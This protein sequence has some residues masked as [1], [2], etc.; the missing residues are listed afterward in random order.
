[1]WAGP[2]LLNLAGAAA[3]VE[4]EEEAST[5]VVELEALAELGGEVLGEGLGDFGGEGFAEFGGEALE[6]LGEL[7]APPRQRRRGTSVTWWEDDTAETLSEPDTYTEH[8]LDSEDGSL[9]ST[10]AST[11]AATTGTTSRP[12]QRSM[13]SFSV[14]VRGG[15][16]PHSLLHGLA[17]H[18]FRGRSVTRR[19]R[20]MPSAALRHR[21]PTHTPSRGP[22]RRSP[23]LMDTGA[24]I[25]AEPAALLRHRFGAP[26]AHVG[27]HHRISRVREDQAESGL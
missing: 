6:G 15:R 19:E 9:S 7:R 14:M 8:T 17:P 25:D 20:R 21:H 2:Y 22:A 23:T 1:M 12:S 4:L 18:G 13:R 5:E 11:S 10:R 16:S 24:P 26:R 27:F 3:A